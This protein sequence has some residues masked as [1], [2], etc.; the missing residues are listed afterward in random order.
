MVPM[1][2][3]QKQKLLELDDIALRLELAIRFIESEIQSQNNSDD[4]LPRIY[5]DPMLD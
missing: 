5:I 2:I 4:I 1:D 3:Y